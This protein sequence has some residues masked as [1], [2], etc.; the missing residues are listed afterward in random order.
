MTITSHVINDLLPAYLSGDAS[1][2]TRVLVEEFLHQHPELADVVAKI[3]QKD[4]DNNDLLKG[5]AM[6]LSPDHEMRTLS[7]TRALLQRRSWMFALALAFSLV[8]VSFAFDGGGI[9]WMMVRDAPQI[10]LVYWVVAGSFWIA[11]L[12]TN[13]R[14]RSSGL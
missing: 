5:P 2:D 12:V 10:A 4:I 3:K 14:L 11:L 9:T 8:P 13:R 6:T 7:R 1:A